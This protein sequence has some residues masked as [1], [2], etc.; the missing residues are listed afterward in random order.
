MNLQLELAELLSSDGCERI[1]EYYLVGP[2]QR[3]AVESF[4][5]AVVSATVTQLALPGATCSP[6][7]K[8]PHGFDRNSSHTANKYVCDC[9]TWDPYDA[10]FQDGFQQALNQE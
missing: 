7:P 1:R 4:F 9:E 6:H 10:G 8:A 2:V 5:E 3:A